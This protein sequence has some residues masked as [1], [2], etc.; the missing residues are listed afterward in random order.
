MTATGSASLEVRTDDVQLD[1]GD[2]ERLVNL[3]HT[4]EDKQCCPCCDFCAARC[5]IRF[6]LAASDGILNFLVRWAYL[7]TPS[8]GTQRALNLLKRSTRRR[9]ISRV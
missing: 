8:K 1:D 9:G 3:C 7:T 6:A 5:A 4:T 2:N